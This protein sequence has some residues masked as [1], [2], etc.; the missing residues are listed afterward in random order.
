MGWKACIPSL[1]RV[2]ALFNKTGCPFNTFSKI[3]HTRGSLLSIIFFADLTVLTIPLS[4]NF[5][6]IKGLYSSAAI[7][8]GNPHSY[9]LRVGPP[10]ITDR[11]E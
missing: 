5:L 8:F 4:I 7:S 1:W 9:N 6:T 2:G 3:S 10:T 11:A